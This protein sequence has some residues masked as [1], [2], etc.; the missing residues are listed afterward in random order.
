VE[1]S[2]IGIKIRLLSRWSHPPT[3]T[4]HPKILNIAIH[5]LGLL[6]LLGIHVEIL[7][8]CILPINFID[9]ALLSF[10]PLM[11]L[12]DNPTAVLHLRWLLEVLHLLL[13][14]IDDWVYQHRVALH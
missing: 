11:M 7:R 8:I 5:H 3:T 13:I 12:W 4:L 9:I 1:L 10:Q 14:P 6:L 2:R